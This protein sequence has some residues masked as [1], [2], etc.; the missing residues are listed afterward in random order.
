M[1]PHLGESSAAHPAEDGR[2]YSMDILVP[3]C[4]RGAGTNLVCF[5]PAGAGSGFFG[6]WKPLVPEHVNLWGVRLPG[7]ES[8]YGRPPFADVETA[9]QHVSAAVRDA[10][11]GEVAL[12]GQCLGA[13]LAYEVALCLEGQLP[14]R[15]L[16]VSGT[17]PPAMTPER[18]GALGPSAPFATVAPT[19][20]AEL[21]AEMAQTTPILTGLATDSELARLLLPVLRTD[22]LMA[23]RY[24][25]SEHCRTLHVPVVAIVGRSADQVLVD[26]LRDWRHL[27]SSRFTQLDVRE[28][29]L[30]LPRAAANL[31]ALLD[32]APAAEA[33]A[34]KG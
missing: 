4:V 23:E 12:L 1:S 16:A 11:T 26:R 30:P 29:A 13:H 31:L 20:D 34:A 33:P 17:G 5:P 28:A 22:L 27:T 7:R 18:S 14:L 10:M 21:L 2:R 19:P 3:M 9:A 25:L 6:A 8:L 24:L 15:W 32:P